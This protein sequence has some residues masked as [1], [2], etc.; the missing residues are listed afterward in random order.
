VRPGDKEVSGF[1]FK[2][3]ANMD[4]N[5]RDRIAFLRL[6]SGEFERGMKLKVQNTGRQLSVNA[7]VIF[8]ASDRELA[9][10]AFAGDVIGIPNHGVLRVGD[11]LSESGTL[12]FAGLPNFAPEILQRVRVKDPLKAKH[13]TRALQ[14]LAEEGVT[15]L[16]RPVMGA[17]FIVGAVGPLQF[18]VM[19]DR[20]ANEYQLEV[21]F[22]PSPYAEARWLAGDKADV[23]DFIAK[24]RGAMAVDIDDQPV[25]LAKTAW[26]IGYVAERF[27]KVR[28]ERAKERA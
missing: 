22:E 12:R 14:G 8:F 28:L 2:I 6:T 5:H 27:P 10:E 23:E 4:P 7:P 15:Q 1:I 21:I 25:F 17:D 16:F 20:L 24:H 3:Q 18:E 19:A 26:E 9:E 11:S 13:L